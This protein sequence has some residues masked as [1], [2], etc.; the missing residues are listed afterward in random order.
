M[1][2][3]KCFLTKLHSAWFVEWTFCPFWM[4]LFLEELLSCSYFWVRLPGSVEASECFIAVTAASLSCQAVVVKR[5]SPLLRCCDGPGLAP[6]VLWESGGAVS[7]ALLPGDGG[8]REGPTP[9]S[10]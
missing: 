10:A 3:M 7:G 5:C 1:L 4:A 2:H 9:L 8:D 6:R